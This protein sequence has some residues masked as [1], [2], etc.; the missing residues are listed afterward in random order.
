V[1]KG[2]ILVLWA[3]VAIAISFLEQATT[4]RTEAFG[5]FAL[6]EGVASV[7]L[8]YGWYH[9][10]KIQHRFRAGPIQNIGIV[11]LPM[12]A[13]P[14]Y[15]I[16]SRGWTDGGIAI[17]LAVAFVLVVGALSMGAELLAGGSFPK[18]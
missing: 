9:L 11:V 17:A 1:S 3:L 8:L 10:D 12:V 15:F 5:M 13:V 14:V 18:F 6:V 7:I 16:R 4:G 2:A